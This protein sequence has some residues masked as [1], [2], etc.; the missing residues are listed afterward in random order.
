MEDYEA[1]NKLLERE[2]SPT[3][4][5]KEVATGS[6]DHLIKIWEVQTGKQLLQLEGH[7]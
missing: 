4:S 5:I 6:H 2:I 1:G 3:V 7:K